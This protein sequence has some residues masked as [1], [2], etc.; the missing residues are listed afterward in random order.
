L[1]IY[2]GNRQRN[3]VDVNTL[4]GQGDW[5]SAIIHTTKSE[6]L[7]A[8]NPTLADFLAV[9][10]AYSGYSPS[11]FYPFAAGFFNPSVFAMSLSLY[12]SNGGP[13]A[14]SVYD[15]FFTDNNTLRL[16]AYGQIDGAPWPMDET[17]D[18][19]VIVQG[20]TLIGGF[21]QTVRNV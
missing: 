21:N 4:Y 13:P 16:L 2:I 5:T 15:F 19:L 11:S 20:L 6:L 18:N 14:E 17:F 10:S 8:G 7:P 9:E 12:A 1:A 3:L